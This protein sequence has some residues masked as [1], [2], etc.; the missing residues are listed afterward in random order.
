MSAADAFSH[1]GA[2]HL[3]AL[4]VVGALALLAALA[5]RRWP[6]LVL[7]RRGRWLVAGL[8]LV[9][10]VGWHLFYAWREPFSPAT[11]LPLH[12]CDVNQL[13]LALYL[14]RPR[15]R[16]FDVVYHWVVTSAALALLFPDL[17]ADFPAPVY[18]SLF[19]S[20]GL[21]LV[22]WCYLVY[23][24]GLRPARRS[25]GLAVTALAAWAAVVAPINAWV[26]GNYLYL[27]EL[28]QVP[29]P[30]IA[31]LP[32]APYYWPIAAG[33]FYLVFRGLR[34]LAPTR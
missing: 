8:L 2:S 11:G 25:A 30:L 27:R 5:P 28:P 10:L 19:S 14:L 26:G 3:A 4:A 24:R 31:W 21:S 34:Q 15:P 18:F 32:P 33:L 29:F 7:A 1:Y 20:H 22:L 23:G 13:L 16:L 12:L 17:P 9:E 6:G